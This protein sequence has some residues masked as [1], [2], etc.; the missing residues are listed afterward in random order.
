[1]SVAVVGAGLAGVRVCEALRRL[2]YDAP[3]TLIGEE[4]HPPYT[5]PPLSKELLR[6]EV[7]PQALTLRDRA[8]LAE[9]GITVRI[10]ERAVHLAAAERRVQLAGDA[11]TA[12][13]V[14]LACG[15]V[16]RSLPG[17]TG[18]NVFTLRTLDDC[19]ALR[20]AM[21]PGARVVVVGAGFIGLEVGASARALGCE[22]TIVDIV[23][24]PLARVLDP[25]LGAAIRRIHES[26]GVGF[27]LGG[28]VADAESADGAVTA[29]RL[30][31]GS[32]VPADAVVVAVGVRPATDW[33]A[34]SGLIVDDGVVCSPDLRAAPGIWAAGDVARWPH[35]PHP[36]P[37]RVEHW[38]NAVEQAAAVAAGIAGRPE[39]YEPVPYFWSDQYDAKLQS[40]G[41]AAGD[42]VRVVA[43]A[44][45]EPKW[46]ALVRGGDRVIG[47][48][49][50]RSAGQVMR[51]K[52]LVAAG[53][54]W[55]EALAAE[56]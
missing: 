56:G 20:A 32:V 8:G 43:G 52:P 55:S 38:T 15:A 41:V 10:G 47:V 49:G 34:D 1:M 30:G 51:R 37:H 14:V 53:V 21:T 7:E 9:L 12:E 26:H 17:V 6:G 36:Q 50:L 25:T 31:D 29:L 40:L 48:V 33:L 54:A 39:P 11:L 24:E 28:G 16:P 3:I 27:R 19:L 4:S 35:A 18:S 22:V 42:E 5:R 2:G 44:L 46:T 13:H 23:T 45:D